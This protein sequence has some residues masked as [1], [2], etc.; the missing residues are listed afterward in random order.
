M[1]C[2]WEQRPESSSYSG[3]ACRGVGGV[4]AQISV[5]SACGGGLVDS[6]SSVNRVRSVLPTCS[7]RR[8]IDMSLPVWFF[9][10]QHLKTSVPSCVIIQIRSEAEFGITTYF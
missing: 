6:A 4:G 5:E 10:S 1:P 9:K 7:A 2:C 3:G 8:Q